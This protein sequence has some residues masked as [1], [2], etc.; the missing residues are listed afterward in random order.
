MAE[1][2]PYL[3][4][5]KAKDTRCSLRKLTKTAAVGMGAKNDGGGES[6]FNIACDQD[7]F[8]FSSSNPGKESGAHNVIN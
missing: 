6:W 8:R 1:G 5:L 2:V 7:W 3:G 4:P